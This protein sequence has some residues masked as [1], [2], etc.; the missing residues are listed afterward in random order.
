MLEKEIIVKEQLAAWC[1]F[2]CSVDGK[3]A[4]SAGTMDYERFAG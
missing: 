4:A 1:L 3:F 2:Q